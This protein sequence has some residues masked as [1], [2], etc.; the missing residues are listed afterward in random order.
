M[1]TLDSLDTAVTESLPSYRA[2]HVAR[3]IT[4]IRAGFD[5]APRDLSPAWVEREVLA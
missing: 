4:A 2:Q 5:V 3:N 1:V